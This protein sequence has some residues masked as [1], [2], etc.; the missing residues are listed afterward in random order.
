[1]LAPAKLQRQIVVSVFVAFGFLLGPMHPAIAQAL[2]PGAPVV[3]GQSAEFSGQSIA[4]EGTLGARAYFDA[5]NK[6]GGVNGH[7]IELK[8]YDDGRDV[9]RSA[10]NTQKLINEDKV[11]A[12]FGYRSTPS[13]EAALPILT[14]ARVPMIAPMSGARQIREPF[15]P[16]VFHMR[17]SYQQEAA[18]MVE[19]LDTVS[20]RKI[21]IL[22]QDDPFG[23]DG[24][25]G[26]QKAMKER[27]L[28]AVAALK[29]D[30]RD[31][32]VDAAVKAIVQ[33]RPQ[34]VLMACTPVACTNFIKQVKRLDSGEQFYMLS[35]VTSDDFVKS[36]GEDGWGVGISQVV[37]YPWGVGLELKTE[38]RSALKD[39]AEPVPVS[40]ASFEG[41]IA[42]KLFVEGLRMAGPN[43]T[44][45]KF[46]AA[47]ESMRD[48]DLG[49]YTVRFSP[50]SH[51]A[52][53]YVDMTVI[54]RD[55]KILR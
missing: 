38:F 5:V 1:M 42:A 2:P 10:A 55:G 8:S 9:K 36:L 40:Y 43:P 44:R 39:A 19:Q 23:Q 15:N 51:N 30:R 7:R 18:K 3:I 54:G 31:L 32:N 16:M 53:N 34:A 52:S 45:E 20:L 13:V 48:Y 33:A 27:G 21:A 17:A 24:L 41:F 46:V 50:T 11:F 49:G 25:E 37:P 12:L 14:A 47:L 26:F 6:R 4:K 29:Y 22:Y 28:T 35:N